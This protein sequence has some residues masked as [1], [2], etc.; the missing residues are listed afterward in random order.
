[1]QI[2]KNSKAARLFDPI[3]AVKND[4]RGFQNVHVSF[5]ATSSCNIAYFNDLN[6][7]TK[8]VETRNKGRGKHK[9]QWAVEINHARRIYLATY[10]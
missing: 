4:L 3:V 9:R 5:Q 2:Q 6:E 7:C 10:L 8:F 1:M